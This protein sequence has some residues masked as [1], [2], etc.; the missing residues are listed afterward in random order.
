MIH[1]DDIYQK[2][3]SAMTTAKVFWSGRSQ[4]V[5]LPKEFRV[6]T[7]ELTIRREGKMIIL[8]QMPQDWAWLEEIQQGLAPDFMAEG[9]ET[10]VSQDR[11]LLDDLFS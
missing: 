1:T 2:R 8:E 10:P 5:R 7:K 3:V 9:R 11:P 4:A 6:K